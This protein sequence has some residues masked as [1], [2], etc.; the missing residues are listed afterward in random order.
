M[1]SRKYYIQ[2]LDFTSS[3]SETGK[4][5]KTEYLLVLQNLMRFKFRDRLKIKSIVILL[6]FLSAYFGVTKHIAI[7]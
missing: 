4:L 3:S 5:E 7:S 6:Y 1:V 2:V